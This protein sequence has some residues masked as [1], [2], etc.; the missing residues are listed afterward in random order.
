ME[1]GVSQRLWL[2][3]KRNVETRYRP[4]GVQTFIDS[5]RA[6]STFDSV[7]IN[8][9]SLGGL[10]DY[11]GDPVQTNIRIYKCP[12]TNQMQIAFKKPPTSGTTP[13]ANSV[14]IK[15][16]TDDYTT[17]QYYANQTVSAVILPLN[18]ESEI[19]TFNI[20][21]D[22][23]TADVIQITYTRR[24]HQIFKACK[25]Q[26]V[27]SHLKEVVDLPNVFILKTDSV[28]FPAVPNLEIHSQ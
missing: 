5:I 15:K 1:N 6:T 14:K 4:C 18:A 24:Q 10:L 21:Y 7:N 17:N 20:E 22:N 13:V 9:N 19:T 16:I 8:T 25:K 3:Y 12:L 28:Q 23:G 2:T 26:T 11:A 27:F